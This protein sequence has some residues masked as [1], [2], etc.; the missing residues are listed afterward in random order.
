MQDKCAKG[1]ASGGRPA[2]LT[3][4]EVLEIRT[5]YD[6]KSGNTYNA[7]SDEYGVSSTAIMAII[8]RKY[9]KHI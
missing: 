5:K 2:K 6:K 8:K 4:E 1:R 7:L 3:S 9:W